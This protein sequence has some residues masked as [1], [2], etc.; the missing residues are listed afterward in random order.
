MGCNDLSSGIRQEHDNSRDVFAQL[1][2]DIDTDNDKFIT[3]YELQKYLEKL[4]TD[5][6]TRNKEINKDNEYF[7]IR[8][9][10]KFKY[11]EVFENK[12]KNIKTN[13]LRLIIEKFVKINLWNFRF[14]TRLFRK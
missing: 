7:D 10:C 3:K 1:F 14:I 2:H 6:I 11:D 8:G 9:V 5:I 13:K 4:R 12:E